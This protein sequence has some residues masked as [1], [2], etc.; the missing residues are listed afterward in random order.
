VSKKIDL[1]IA[2]LTGAAIHGGA[3]AVNVEFSGWF[4]E[5]SM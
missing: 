2:A 1:P 3:A 4:A 5:I